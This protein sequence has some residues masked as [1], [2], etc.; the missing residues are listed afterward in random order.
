MISLCASCCVFVFNILCFI[1]V[2]TDFDLENSIGC[3]YDYVAVS[4][5]IRGHFFSFW[6]FFVHKPFMS[7]PLTSRYS[8]GHVVLDLLIYR[9]LIFWFFLASSSTDPPP[10][11]QRWRRSAAPS[12]H[13]SPP[14]R[15]PTRW[16]SNSAAICPLTDV[17]FI[18]RINPVRKGGGEFNNPWLSSL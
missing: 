12:L 5:L 4:R 9:T 11:S 14:W 10:M 6:L 18:W 7:L 13:R 16:K 15:R 3:K 2:T 1:L 17:A 8:T